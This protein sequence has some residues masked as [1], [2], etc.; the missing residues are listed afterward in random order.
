MH[1]Q[2]TRGPLGWR[3]TLPFISR[4]RHL[5]ELA[6][7]NADRERLREERD[8]FAADRDTHRR[9]ADSMSEKYAD[10]CIANECLERDL[11]A[12]R[13]NQSQDTDSLQKYVQALEQQLDHALGM[14][15]TAVE[16]GRHWQQTRQDKGTV[17]P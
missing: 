12:A 8:Q 10:T 9:A 7:V 13:A 3:P 17:R 15:G 6:A 2:N 14:N 4:R 11:A 5:A 1:Q 16:D